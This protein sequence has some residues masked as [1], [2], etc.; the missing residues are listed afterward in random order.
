MLYKNFSS[1]LVGA[2]VVSGCVVG[3][4][5]PVDSEME[6][7]LREQQSE[8]YSGDVVEGAGPDGR[9]K[10]IVRLVSDGCTGF[11]ITGRHILTAAHCFSA[12]GSREIRYEAPGLARRTVTATITR[13]PCYRDGGLSCDQAIVTL[14]SND[15][16]ATSSKR[17]WLYGGPTTKGTWLHAYGYG[18]A[19]YDG[20]GHG[21]LRTAP[22]HASFAITS[23]T[24]GYFEGEAYGTR[25]CAGDSGG[26]VMVESSN[27]AT[28]PIVWGTV[29]G[30]RTNREHCT[31]RG[32]TMHFSKTTT[33]MAF[34]ESVIGRRCVAP[35]GNPA[36]NPRQCW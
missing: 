1:L 33:N 29:V 25:T 7:F 32:D 3:A 18:Y 9:W 24:D 23:H 31:G 11:F 20:S 10:G 35:A 8:I 21:K 36:G 27:P 4:D 26:P 16:W 34:Y 17:F 2:V 14:P 30:A 12:N 15:A 28:R 6:E 22:N 19:N 5:G 13:N